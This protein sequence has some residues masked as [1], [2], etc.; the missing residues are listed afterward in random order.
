MTTLSAVCRAMVKQ[1]NELARYGAAETFEVVIDQDSWD[2][3]KDDLKRK[4]AY[5]ALLYGTKLLGC[6]VLVDPT[7][8]RRWVEVRVVVGGILRRG[9]S[10]PETVAGELV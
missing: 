8:A 10:P 6:T 7:P 9:H 5:P 1:M 2:E 3:M 4:S